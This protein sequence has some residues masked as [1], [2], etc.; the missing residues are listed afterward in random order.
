MSNNK[1]NEN[2]TIRKK[3]EVQDGHYEYDELNDKYNHVVPISIVSEKPD[4]SKLLFENS[5]IHIDRNGD[6][7]IKRTNADRIRNMSDEELN[8]IFSES[9]QNGISDS[10]AWEW[11]QRQNTFVQTIEWLQSESEE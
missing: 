10:T 1:I 5:K 4:Y 11:G 2:I 8:E 6:V 9:Y 7:Q 3:M